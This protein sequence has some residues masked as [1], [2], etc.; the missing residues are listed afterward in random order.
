SMD[1]RSFFEA[2]PP[3][4]QRSY[5]RNV[6]YAELKASGRE[7]NDSDSKRAGSYLRGREAIATLFP[8]QD[9]QGKALSYTGDLT[10]Y[11]SALY[12]DADYVNNT[13]GKSRPNPKLD[14]ITKAEWEALGSP[15]YNVSFYDVLDAGIH[16]NF[17]GDI[18][19]LTPGGRALVGIDGGFN[20]GPGSGVITQ[21]E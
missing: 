14:Y 17:G 15:G 19:I 4:Q 21:G 7:Y 16:T 20:P 9:A 8:E 18:S 3:E 1:A 13:T 2:L 12:Y 11:S 6:Y 5:L 10:M